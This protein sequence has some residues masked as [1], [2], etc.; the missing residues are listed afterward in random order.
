MKK[1]IF[2]LMVI[3]LWLSL[4]NMGLAQDDMKEIT[5]CLYCG[6]DRAK[7]AHSRMLV[8]YEDGTREG[9]CSLHCAAIDLAANIDMTPKTINVGDYVTKKLIDAE[10]AFWVIGGSKT[11]V[12]TKR[13][14]WAFEKKEAAEK[15][16]KENGGNIST[17]DEALKAA[18]E[19]MYADIKMIRD[20]RKMKKMEPKK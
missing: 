15:F 6:M 7:F 5:E 14:K 1:T 13:A 4:G 18:Y 12:M 11:G 19:D 16:V 20:R 2:I 3:G 8:E 17:F 9:M 10:K